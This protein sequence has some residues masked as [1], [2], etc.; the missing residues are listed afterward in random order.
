MTNREES[1]AAEHE[2]FPGPGPLK[3]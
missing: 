1:G 3:T 2:N